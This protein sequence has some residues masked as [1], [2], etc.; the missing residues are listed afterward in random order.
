MET[1]YHDL[2]NVVEVSDIAGLTIPRARLLHDAITH[3]RDYTLVKLLQHS[4]EARQRL[5]A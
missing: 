2:A 4:T 1:E 5:N 3:Q